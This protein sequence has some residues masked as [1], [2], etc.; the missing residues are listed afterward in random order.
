MF[1]FSATHRLEIVQGD[2]TTQPLDAIVNAANERLLHG[3]GVAAAIARKAGRD[4]IEES[5]AWVRQ[6]GPLTHDSPAITTAGNLPCRY[7][8]HAVGPVWH[9]GTHGEDEA[10]STAVYGALR[11]AANLK[12]TSLALPAIAT[13]I[14][15]Y[16]FARAIGVTLQALSDYFRAQPDSPLNLVR[17]VLY[18]R[19]AL[20]IALRI[21]NESL[22]PA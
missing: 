9:G 14:F 3:G 15:G 16:P 21:A 20:E 8:I 19:R 7:V 5:R 2:I 11:C 13:G 17:L 10:L 22:R 1:P 18:D 6:H 12:L 4:L